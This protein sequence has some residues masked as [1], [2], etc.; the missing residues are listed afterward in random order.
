MYTRKC[1]HTYTH[2]EGRTSDDETNEQ[3]E[4]INDS[5][6]ANIPLTRA[7]KLTFNDEQW[8]VRFTRE[9]KEQYFALDSRPHLQRAILHILQRLA[10]GEQARSLMKQLKGTPR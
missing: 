7:S 4:E 3:E 6:D 1:T 10:S 8:D 2:T 9:F 5:E